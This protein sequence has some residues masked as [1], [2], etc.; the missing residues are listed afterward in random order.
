MKSH[1]PKSKKKWILS[2]LSLFF[3]L[4]FVFSAGMAAVE[5]HRTKMEQEAFLRLAEEMRQKQEE[6][7]L[8]AEQEKMEQ[9]QVYDALQKKNPDFAAWLKVDGTAIDYPVMHTPDDEEYYLHRAFD[10]SDSIS[11]TPFIGARSD[12]NSDYFIIYG[13]NMN[14]DTMFGTLD[15]YQ[16]ENFYKEHP[17]LT[18]T[19]P[20]EERV[21]EIFAAIETRVLYQDE[22]GFRYY[23][24][25]GELTEDDWHAFLDWIKINALYETGITPVYG[26]QILI[27]STCSYHTEQGRFVIAARRIM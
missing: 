17:R 6:K 12:L 24:L 19:T 22:S 14:N 4:A 8:T 13:H 9:F 2:F 26:E 18:L 15:L 21:Y 11:G 23:D 20:Q 1:F 7:A 27:L 3:F 25:P 16:E 10:G 5:Y